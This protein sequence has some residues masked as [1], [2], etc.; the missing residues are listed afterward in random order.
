MKTNQQPQGVEYIVQAK[1][2]YRKHSRGLTWEEKVAS[3][4]RMLELSGRI[5]R[6]SAPRKRA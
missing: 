3:M 6:G 1:K 4:E 2:I 5:R